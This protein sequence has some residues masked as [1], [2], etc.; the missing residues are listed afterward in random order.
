MIFR[1][2]LEYG[3]SEYIRQFGMTIDDNELLGIDARV[4]KAPR[5][6]Y[7]PASRQPNV[8][9]VRAFPPLMME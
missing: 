4:I 1:Q 8:V 5:L 2:V 7:N 9:L 6:K 3:Q